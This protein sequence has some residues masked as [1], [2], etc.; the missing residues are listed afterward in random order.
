[1]V[2]QLI[3]N[4]QV[5]GSS[6]IFSLFFYIIKVTI[7]IFNRYHSLRCVQIY[8]RGGAVRMPHEHLQLIEVNRAGVNLMYHKVSSIVYDGANAE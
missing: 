1:M 5:V 7:G 6:P 8:L 3:R 2:E 4:Q